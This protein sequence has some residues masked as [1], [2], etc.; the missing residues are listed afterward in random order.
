MISFFNYILKNSGLLT[1]K[2][3][4][5]CSTPFCDPT[6]ICFQCQAFLQRCFFQK[7]TPPTGLPFPVEFLFSWRNNGDTRIKN[8]IYALKRGRPNK[9][10]RYLLHEFFPVYQKKFS[11]SS[12]WVIVSAPSQHPP[13]FDHA[14]YMGQTLSQFLDIPTLRP[15]Q[16]KSHKPQK[17]LSKQKRR[18]NLSLIQ[19]EATP[20]HKKIL[21]VDDVITTGA[22][23][24]KTWEALGRPINFFVFC[25][26]HKAKEDPWTMS[27]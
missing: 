26:A 14:F 17:N 15:L 8:L 1:G 18:E 22:T 21:F 27:P 23:A 2:H 25:W 16:L 24:Q 4:L 7:Q 19:L 12:E 5:L 3:C 9:T 20:N 6:Q 10:Y 11:N 13:Q